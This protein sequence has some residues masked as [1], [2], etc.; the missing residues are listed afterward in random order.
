VRRSKGWMR[1]PSGL[2]CQQGT[3]NNKNSRLENGIIPFPRHFQAIF[4]HY[5]YFI[6]VFPVFLAFFVG[7][8]RIDPY[9]ATDCSIKQVNR[10]ML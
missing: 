4:T 7:F 1:R 8:R 2:L 5:P 3:S 9:L 6:C 10:R